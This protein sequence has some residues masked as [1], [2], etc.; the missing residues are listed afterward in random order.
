MVL[1]TLPGECIIIRA[2]S[3]RLCGACEGA[4]IRRQW[5]PFT[6]LSRCFFPVSQQLGIRKFQLTMHLLVKYEFFLNTFIKLK[7]KKKK[8]KLQGTATFLII[9]FHEEWL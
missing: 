8:S 6:D 2:Y 1:V 5:A 7:I 3:E 9:L 4:T